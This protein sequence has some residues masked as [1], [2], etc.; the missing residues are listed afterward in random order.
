MKEEKT[1]EAVQTANAVPAIYGALSKIM[2]ETNAIGKN[3][4]NQSQNFNFRG[5]DDVMNSLHNIFAKN[6]VFILPQVEN[7][8]IAE[9]TTRNGNIQFCTRA[10]ICFRFVCGIDGSSIE[11]RMV[12]EAMDTGDKGMNKA[13]SI[14]LKYT[15]MQMLL[16]PTQEMQNPDAQTPE[17]MRRRTIAE[18]AS[19]YTQSD[20]MLCAVLHMIAGA[21][22]REELA[23]IYKDNVAYQKN[24]VFIGALNA[25]QTEINIPAA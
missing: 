3:Q 14:A 25:R 10:N 18:V 6:H 19:D 4:H 16:I 15:L 13:M 22:T 8:T 23:G 21:R 12:G 17:P 24:D 2:A 11:T 1:T 20:P 5:I 7:Y 9:K